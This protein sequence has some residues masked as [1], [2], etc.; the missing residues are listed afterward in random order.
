MCIYY[1]CNHGSAAGDKI[2][3]YDVKQANIIDGRIPH[4][5]LIELLTN[6]GA[7]TMII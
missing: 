3:Q 4:S 6:E 2:K 7:G 1:G 5:I